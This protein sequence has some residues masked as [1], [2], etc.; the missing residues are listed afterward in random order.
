M[1]STRLDAILD[2]G[3]LDGL[4]EMGMDDLRAR[5]TECQAIETTL[6]FARR[7]VQA[8]LD[9]IGTELERRG[10]GQPRATVAELVERLQAG[11]VL[12]GQARPEGFGRLP[13]LLAPDEA[14]LDDI[15]RAAAEYGNVELE[16]IPDLDDADLAQ[17]ADG[18]SAYERE[19]SDQ[20][21]QVFERIDALQAEMV[22]R[23]KSGAANVDTLLK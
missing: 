22:A 15:T 20:R 5:R 12:G 9:I 17:L 21:R 18:L 13:T 2:P 19:V 8:R 4:A 16:R 14:D 23:Y 11:E 10:R 6:S 7:L 1:G 3:Y